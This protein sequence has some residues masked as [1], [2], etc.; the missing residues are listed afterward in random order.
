MPKPIVCLSEQLCQYLACFRPCFSKR[1]WKYFVTVLLGLIE[2]E[3]RKTMTGLLRVVGERISLSGLS[4]F[5]N[6]WPWSMEAVTEIWQARFRERLHC[7]VQEDHKRQGVERPRRRGRPKRTV[8]TGY[9]IFDDSVHIKPKGRSMGGLGKHYSNTEGRLVD[10]HCLFTGLYVLLGQRCPLAA[11]LY[12]Q[13]AV[14]EREGVP[15]QSKIDMAVSEI[16]D[17]EPVADT[18]THVLVDSWYHCQRVRKAAQARHWHLSGGLKSNRVMRLVAEDGSR[19]WLSLSEYAARLQPADW[20][21]VTWPSA[22]EGQPMYAHL[23]RTRIRKLGPILL[24]ITC[25]DLAAPR[26]TVRYWGSSQ[27]DLNHQALVDILAIRWQ[28]ETF[29]EYEKDLLGSDHYQVMSAQAILRFWTLVAC[30]MCFLEEQ[31]SSHQVQG[32]TCGD[33]RRNVQHQHRLNL[34][35]W[36]AESFQAGATIEQIGNQLA[37][38]SS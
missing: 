33:V 35:Q 20:Q 16:E 29:F 28:I 4:R 34:L 25:H 31:R 12:R 24:L 32:L 17:F 15:F 13:K 36:L 8:V 30:L 38:F 5:M 7:Q 23:V 3:E 10:G 21:E 14:C 9:L 2:C 26:R 1:Q 6:R 18:Q 19:E 37:L 22:Q 11:R 27:L